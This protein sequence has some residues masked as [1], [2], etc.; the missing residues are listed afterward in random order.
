MTERLHNQEPTYNKLCDAVLARLDDP[1][2]AQ[3]VLHE[4]TGRYLR[5]QPTSPLVRSLSRLATYLYEP[6]VSPGEAACVG[7]GT[8]DKAGE[9]TLSHVVYMPRHFDTE[10]YIDDWGDTPVLTVGKEE[11]GAEK[12]GFFANQQPVA[13]DAVLELIQSS[14]PLP[15]NFTSVRIDNYYD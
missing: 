4:R 6:S 14:T 13:R 11:Y 2:V 8:V 7:L 5:V 1:A 10:E 9:L 3:N 15:A 12:V